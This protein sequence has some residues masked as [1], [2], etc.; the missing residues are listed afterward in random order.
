MQLA[1]NCKKHDTKQSKIP[2]TLYVTVMIARVGK[3]VKRRISTA[4]EQ[5]ISERPKHL[6]FF[7]TVAL[8]EACACR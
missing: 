3:P 8:A 6:R 7:R 4:M 2:T 5:T 1:Q